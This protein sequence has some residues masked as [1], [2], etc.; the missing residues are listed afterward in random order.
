[1][2][3]KLAAQVLR[4]VVERCDEYVIYL[5]SLLVSALNELKI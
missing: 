1:M 2:L 4:A 3:D 5:V